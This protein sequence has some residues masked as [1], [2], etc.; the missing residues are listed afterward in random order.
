[1]RDL[2]NF[3]GSIPPLSHAPTPHLPPG[4]TYVAALLAREL[5]LQPIVVGPRMVLPK[6]RALLGD[7]TIVLSYAELASTDA[8]KRTNGSLE[9]RPLPHGLLE[10]ADAPTRADGP[11]FRASTLY[12]AR[13]VRGVLLI[14]DEIHHLKNTEAQCSAAAQRLIR[15][16]LAAAAAAGA[17]GAAEGA[18]PPPPMRSRVLL[19]GA[20]PINKREMAGGLL[21]TVGLP[22]EHT[23]LT[24]ACARIDAAAT[25]RAAAEGWPRHREHAAVVFDGEAERALRRLDTAFDERSRALVY[26]QVAYWRRQAQRQR[27]RTVE[28]LEAHALATADRGVSPIAFDLFVG[29][30]KPAYSSTIRRPAPIVP[31]ITNSFCALDGDALT[32]WRQ[33]CAELEHF[34]RVRAA[35]RLDGA[36]EEADETAGETDLSDEDAYL[37]TSKMLRN[38]FVLAGGSSLAAERVESS[39]VSTFVRLA[40][41]ALASSPHTKVVVAVNFLATVSAVAAGLAAHAPLV[42]EGA[43]PAAER[44]RALAAFQHASP[45]FRVLV[46]SIATVNAGIDLDDKDGNFPRV[47]LVSPS[48]RAIHQ[49]QFMGRFTRADTVKADDAPPPRIRIVWARDPEEV[50]VFREEALQESLRSQG[51][52]LDAF[53]RDA[54]NE[55]E[56]TFRYPTELL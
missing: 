13:V 39:K 19:V 55:G 23:A 15:P 6:W 20:T 32:K 40:G 24:Q 56:G 10:R 27:D 18:A 14:F 51:S 48:G 49:L 4:K 45:T 8:K 22:T 31:A 11:S 52:V 41:E 29:V 44:E 30:V 35:R 46:A 5:G 36:L 25:A 37:V 42:I 1:M 38:D 2:A 47:A 53:V 9:F 17:A 33:S 12:L 16:I 28:E 54:P 43:T 34:G 26:S 50:A 3:G 7:M 21:A